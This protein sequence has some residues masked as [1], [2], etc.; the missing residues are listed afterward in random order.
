MTLEDLIGKDMTPGA[1]PL[2]W[3]GRQ[4]DGALV[5]QVEKMQSEIAAIAEV[6]AGRPAPVTPELIAFAKALRRDASVPVRVFVPGEGIAPAAAGLA[7]L[8]GVTVTGLEGRALAAYSAEAWKSVLAPRLAALKP[9]FVCIAHDAVGADFGPGLAARLGAACITSVEG[10]RKEK[11]GVVFRRPFLNGKMRMEIVPEAEMTVVTLLPGAFRREETRPSA[12]DQAGRH[13]ETLLPDNLYNRMPTA[14]WGGKGGLAAPETP[15]VIPV[16]DLP[17]KTRPLGLLPAPDEDTDLTAAEVIVAAGRGI[18]GGENLALLRQ[19]ASLFS[20]S[21]IGASRGVCDAGWLPQRLQIGQTGKTVAPRLYIAC[22]I[23]GALQHLAGMRGSQC[24]VAINRDPRAAIFQA[25]DV[26]VVEELVSFLPLL[27]DACRRQQGTWKRGRIMTDA[28]L[29]RKTQLF[30]LALL[31]AIFL[32][33]FLS[34]VVLA[35]LMPVIEQDLHLGHAGAG[36]IFMLIAIGY[37]A[38]LFGSGFVSSRLTHRRTIVMAAVACGCSILLIAVKPQPLGDP[39][40]S[41]SPRRFHRDLSPLGDDDDH[42]LDPPRSLGKGDRRPR[43][44]AGSRFHPCTVRRR[45]TPRLLALA[46]GSG[47]DR[48][49]LRQSWA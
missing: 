3:K 48:C 47:R 19:L 32:M 26:A 33:N 43:T 7:V 10:F 20:R 49:H 46:G 14:E 6:A 25:A 4:K 31:T 29:S 35:P 36:G 27:I 11:D 28:S 39:S 22:G 5:R 9:R 41:D 17:L 30:L 45:R 23:S 40:R 12:E 1:S 38:G 15:E 13:G 21:A 34:R 37:A 42:R 16:K 18:G 8:P 24:I 44:R 2:P